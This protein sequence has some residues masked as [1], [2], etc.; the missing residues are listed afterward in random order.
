MNNILHFTADMLEK[1]IYYR[2]CCAL[3]CMALHQAIAIADS[4]CNATSSRN[5]NKHLWFNDPF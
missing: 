2:Y 4:P 3:R 1:L 5:G